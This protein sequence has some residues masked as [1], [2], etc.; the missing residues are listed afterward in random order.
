MVQQSLISSTYAHFPQQRS[1]GCA[2][3]SF[4]LTD[5]NEADLRNG[6]TMLQN[7]CRNRDS[8]YKPNTQSYYTLPFR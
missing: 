3:A 7:H 2:N 1:S 6:D 5:M 4:E 8:L